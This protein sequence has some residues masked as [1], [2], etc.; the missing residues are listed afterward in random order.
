MFYSLYNVQWRYLQSHLY[1]GHQ[2]VYS[3]SKT[4]D[5]CHSRLL[6]DKICTGHLEIGQSFLN[7]FVINALSWAA[8]IT[9]SV[10]MKQR[11][12]R[13]L[14]FLVMNAHSDFSHAKEAQ[15][16]LVEHLR[17]LRKFRGLVKSP[18]VPC[19]HPQHCFRTEY[20]CFQSISSRKG[21]TATRHGISTWQ[22]ACMSP[23]C[24]LASLL[25]P[26]LWKCLVLV[27]VTNFFFPEG[28]VN[29][30]PN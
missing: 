23:D 24:W 21:L 6:R 14:N 28:V 5:G 11:V 25:C 9:L 15:P 7:P 2:Q 17:H 13:I 10:W 29:P 1:S 8:R 4:S 16:V 18:Y 22:D 19:A 3:Y 12:S 27:S 26:T 20:I 30:M